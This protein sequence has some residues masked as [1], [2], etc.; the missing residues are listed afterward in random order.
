M[1]SKS[2]LRITIDVAGKPRTVLSL[3]EKD[4]GTLNLY[5]KPAK[6]SRNDPLKNKITGEF[7][8]SKYSLHMTPS[9]P[10][11]NLFHLTMR[12]SDQRPDE[13][14]GGYQYT[15]AIKSYTRFAPIFY[16]RVPDL[17]SAEFSP[18]PAKRGSLSLG[19][20][21]PGAQTLFI[22]VAVGPT[23][24]VLMRTEDPLKK[25]H[26]IQRHFSF[27]SLIVFWWFLDIPSH[28]TGSA[29]HPQ[30]TKF[31]EDLT[32]AQRWSMTD[33]T[34]GCNDVELVAYVSSFGEMLAHSYFKFLK[35]HEPSFA[36]P[37]PVS[38]VLE[39]I[40]GPPDGPQ[41]HPI[42]V[43]LIRRIVRGE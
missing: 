34:N 42:D 16:R 13:K 23:G 19:S 26:H 21:T 33:L 2:A 5:L 18:S 10:T 29:L 20:M 24:R 4:D 15:R 41:L 27:F 40:V 14:I 43:D 8:V 22:G 32:E 11:G 37:A 6:Y 25:V 30:T 39:P 1:G 17:N 3:N 31:T 9:D 28:Y 7:L 35:E 36:M 38:K 12:T